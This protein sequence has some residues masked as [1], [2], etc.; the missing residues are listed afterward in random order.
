M[1]C[2]IWVRS[3]AYTFDIS[4]SRFVPM[5]LA[6][7]YIYFAR[8]FL[9]SNEIKF[10]KR[11][12]LQEDKK[13]RSMHA[14]HFIDPLIN[15][16]GRFIRACKWHF[17]E[18]EPPSVFAFRGE[19]MIYIIDSTNFSSN[20]TNSRLGRPCLCVL[21]H[22]IVL[23]MNRVIVFVLAE[24]RCSGW[25]RRLFAPPRFMQLN[26]SENGGLQCREKYREGKEN[27]VRKSI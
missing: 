14:C 23:P 16:R 19:P 25:K 18:S 22:V 20:S 9:V 27:L 1:I 17:A 6:Y 8:T 5:H 10:R 13:Q 15:S 2:Q 7:I 24:F 12:I 11:R 21:W 4:R 26:L 3:F